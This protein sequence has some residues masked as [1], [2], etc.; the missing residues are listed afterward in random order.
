MVD[1]RA[2][3]SQSQQQ[4]QSQPQSQHRHR[5]GQSLDLPPSYG[6]HQGDLMIAA[7][8]VRP[9]SGHGDGY[10]YGYGGGGDVQEHRRDGLSRWG[11]VARRING[12]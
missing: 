5:Y 4:S 12:R 11:A 7:Q 9:S 1:S 8:P 10:G 2:V 3:Q 6:N